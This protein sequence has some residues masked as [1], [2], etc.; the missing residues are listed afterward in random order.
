MS[1]KIAVLV[2]D[3]DN[4]LGVKAKVKGPVIGEEANKKAA[5]EL[6]L[7]DPED[8]DS[9]AIMKAVSVYL[10]LKSQGKDV[11]IATLTGSEKLGYQALSQLSKQLDYLI[12]NYG[13]NKVILITDGKMDEEILP[14]LQSRGIKIE[15]IESIYIKQSKALEKTY[16]LILDKLKDPYYAK[17]LLGIPALILV[18]I[19]LIYAFDIKWHYFTALIGIYLLMKGFNIDQYIEEMFK[20][21]QIGQ[22]K[23]LRI[24]FSIVGL[25]L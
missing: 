12:E 10:D 8:S 17:Y 3:I 24:V 6:A 5:M 11:V 4:D 18:G 16:L 1:D 19:S 25:L 21:L 9:N 15:G 14:M 7:A 13:I 23:K 20:F 22:D 2:V